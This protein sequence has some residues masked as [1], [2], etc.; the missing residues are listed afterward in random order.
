MMDT[1]VVRGPIIL[2]DAAISPED[3][4]HAQGLAP[5]RTPESACCEDVNV[6]QRGVLASITAEVR[7]RP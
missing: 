5:T 3:V 4:L 1:F 6:G 7:A 2:P